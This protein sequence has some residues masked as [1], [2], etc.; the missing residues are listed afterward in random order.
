MRC[1]SLE[2]WRV[3][4]FVTAVYYQACP[5]C[6]PSK[7]P[8]LCGFAACCAEGPRLSV[9]RPVR[10]CPS[11]H[12]RR[13]SL[14]AREQ[15]EPGGEIGR[16]ARGS[17]RSGAAEP[18]ERQKLSLISTAL[19]CDHRTRFLKISG[20]LRKTGPGSAGRACTTR[21]CVDAL[22]G[23]HAGFWFRLSAVRLLEVEMSGAVL[24][25]SVFTLRYSVLH[26]TLTLPKF[27]GLILKGFVSG[28]PSGHVNV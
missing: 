9:A 4:L 15:R 19:V 12:A 25:I 1:S 18:L 13:R 10:P 27:P 20:A 24:K 14:R 8:A 5:N 6:D 11:L 17:P 28:S 2:R 7:L 3:R 21:H 23:S 16:K 26:L 22:S